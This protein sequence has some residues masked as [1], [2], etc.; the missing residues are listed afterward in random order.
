MVWYKPSAIILSPPIK[1]PLVWK[2]VQLPF[3][4]IYLWLLSWRKWSCFYVIMAVVSISSSQSCSKQFQ[5]KKKKSYRGSKAYSSPLLIHSWRT[6]NEHWLSKLP[7]CL[8][9]SSTNPGCPLP[10]NS[11]CRN[12]MFLIPLSPSGLSSSF[13]LF[14]SVFRKVYKNKFFF[15]LCL[16]CCS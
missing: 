7:A 9:N 4:P 8:R 3:W 5:E 6:L 1:S 11:P 14:L 16:I 12:P 2:D 15:S 10:G 13:A